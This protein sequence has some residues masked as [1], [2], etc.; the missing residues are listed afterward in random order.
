MKTSRI[1]QYSLVRASLDSIPD[2][3][4]KL[5]PFIH[6]KI[7]VFLG[8]VPK[9]PGH[10]VVAEYPTGIII[11]GYHVDWFLEIPEDET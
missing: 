5:Y 3:S 11:S 2:E 10:C 7:Y 4:R 9:M 1:K 6:G 8:E